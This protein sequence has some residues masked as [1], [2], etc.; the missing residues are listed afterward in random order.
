MSH[1]IVPDSGH[2]Y[3]RF[4]MSG[5][6][7]RC[8]VDN[9]NIKTQVYNLLHQLLDTR[10]VSHIQQTFT[11]L[12]GYNHWIANSLVTSLRTICLKAEQIVLK[13]DGL[14]VSD[15][16]S[17]NQTSCLKF[18]QDV[19][20]SQDTLF[21]KQSISSSTLY[22]SLFKGYLCGI[23]DDQQCCATTMTLLHKDLTFYVINCEV[24]CIVEV[25]SR[26]Y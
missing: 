8:D 26:R 13:A 17:Q 12:F 16:M 15:S 1:D 24:A 3:A 14:E 6:G 5:C 9:L 10:L 18:G 21:S 19:A 2:W 11:G 25:I 7:Y 22:W 20:G 4:H 23:T